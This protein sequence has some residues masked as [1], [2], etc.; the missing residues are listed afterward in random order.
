M[1]SILLLLAWDWA[2]AP[3]QEPTGNRAFLGSISPHQLAFSGLR[4]IRQPSKSSLPGPGSPASFRHSQALP[5]HWPWEPAAQRPWGQEK[6][7]PQAL[8]LRE[9]RAAQS[10][11]IPG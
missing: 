2:V 1:G 10:K 7:H 6:G 8:V 5:G 3:P 9:G 11:C 4:T